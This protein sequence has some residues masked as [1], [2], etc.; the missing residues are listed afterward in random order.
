MA[1]PQR[2]RRI[3]REP[4]IASFSPDG[5]A[6]LRSDATV[7]L[8]VDEYEVIR[9]V[10]F[11]GR[12]HEQCA[13]HIGVSRT[14]VTE[15]YERARRKIADVLVNGKHL[16]IAGGNYLVCNGSAG[17]CADLTCSMKSCAT[18]TMEG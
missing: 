16:L 5:L 4:K 17:G 7:T 1:R 2:S 11:E 18:N 9:L 15:I 10:D 12:T 6:G 3:C 14:T 8:S 13:E